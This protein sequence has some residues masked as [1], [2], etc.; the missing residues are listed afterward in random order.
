MAYRFKSEGITALM[1]QI[2]KLDD[3]AEFIASQALFDGA[4]VVAAEINK[5]AKSIQTAPFKYAK[6][7]ET[8]MPSPE[9]KEIIT[10]NGAVGIAKFRRNLGSVDT[11]VGYNGSGYAPVTWNHMNSMARTNY[12]ATPFKG[13]DV[14]ASSTLK[15]LRNQGGS[16]KY[17]I[18]ATIG[19]G[20]QDMK[21]VGVVA[22][23]INSGTSFMKKQPFMRKAFTAAKPRCEAAIIKR[24]ESLLDTIL[25]EKES[26][27]KSA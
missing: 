14:T 8:R 19:K 24:A 13:N 17:G 18:S 20:D 22:N 4:G 3:K 9:E 23:S 21:P 26:G 6:P 2:A 27:G 5:Q 10:N 15:W 11:S 7:G 1:K 12:K 16:E 25:N